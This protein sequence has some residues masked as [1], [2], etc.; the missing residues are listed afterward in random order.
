MKQLRKSRKFTDQFRPVHELSEKVTALVG[1]QK[2]SQKKRELL[3]NH[4]KCW[5]WGRH[6]VLETL[7][8]GRWLPLEVVACPEML[9]VEQQQELSALQ[10]TLRFPFQT[11]SSE[12]LRRFC[13]SQEHQGLMAKMPSFPYGDPDELLRRLP[14]DSAVLVLCGIQDPFNFGSI[15]RSADLFGINAVVVPKAGQAAVSSHVVR[16]S[17]GAVNYLTIVQVD[18]LLLYC[19][20]LQGAGLK[21]HAATERGNLAPAQVSLTGPLAILIGNEGSGVPPELIEL[22]DVQLA[23]PQTGH[24]GSLNAAVAAGILC[25]EVQRQRRST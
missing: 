14:E 15:L 9:T 24:V 13:G 18:Q 5:L 2:Q 11:A 3:G 10:R 1:R 23:I 7:R 19:R 12:E 25:Y 8:A 4:Q 16:S 22:S 21:L 20:Q 17:V 6:A